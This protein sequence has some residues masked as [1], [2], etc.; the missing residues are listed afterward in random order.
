[1][2]S[3]GPREEIGLLTVM[4]TSRQGVV[5]IVIRGEADLATREQLRTGLAGVELGPASLVYLDLSRL[6]FCDSASCRVLL[7]FK[8][9]NQAAGHLVRIYRASPHVR[10]IMDLVEDV[11]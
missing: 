1:M 2:D 11:G 7:R 6:T 3:P 8:K 5:W 4:S 10:R 9:Q